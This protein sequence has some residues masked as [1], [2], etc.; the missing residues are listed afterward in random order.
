M[1]LTCCFFVGG[2]AMVNNKLCKYYM[3]ILIICFV[4]CVIGTD[5]MYVLADESYKVY[6]DDEDI[7]EFIDGTGTYFDKA[8][9][10]Y[11]DNEGNVVYCVQAGIAGADKN[12]ISGYN[13]GGAQII[14][15]PELLEKLNHITSLGYPN[16]YSQYA[17]GGT[18]DSPIYSSGLLISGEILK[19]TED[20]A[21]AATAFAIHKLMVDNKSIYPEAAYGNDIT[22]NSYVNKSTA[23]CDMVKIIDKLYSLE[24]KGEASI[25]IEWVIL[26]GEE[27]ITSENP[28][29]TGQGMD[30]YMTL[31]AR[32]TSNNCVV[33]NISLINQEGYV[34]GASIKEIQ[35]LSAFERLV[36]IEIQDNAENYLRNVG[37]NCEAV[38][39]TLSNIKIMG[40]TSYQDIAVVT[41]PGKL[42]QSI[43][44]RFSD[45]KMGIQKLDY[46]TKM[47]IK[48]VTFGLYSDE[49]CNNEIARVITDENGFASLEDIEPGKYY[50]KELDCPLGYVLDDSIYDLDILPDLDTCVV[51]YNQRVPITI[52]INKTDRETGRSEPQGDAKL[53]GAK[54]GVYAAEDI[55]RID[56]CSGIVTKKDELVGQITI[57]FKNMG[58]IDG[59]YPG[60]Y[61]IR[62]I[63]APVGYKLDDTKYFVD[64]TISSHSITDIRQNIV[65]S[66]DV[67]KQ[68][69]QLIK[70]YEGRNDEEIYLEGAGFSAWL[71]SDL[72]TDENGEYIVEGCEPYPIGKDGGIE[73]FTD[74]NGYAC[75]KEIPY[76][77]YLVRETTVPEGF[78]PIED[79]IITISEDSD[80]P[81]ELGMLKDEH[82]VSKI[83]VLKKDFESGVNIVGAELAL[84]D[85]A[86]TEIDR[87][88]S[89]NEEHIIEGLTI[90]EKYIL[91]EI[92]A[93]YG[94]LLANDIEFYP[95][96]LDELLLVMYDKSPKGKITIYKTGEIVETIE[97]KNTAVGVAMGVEVGVKDSWLSGVE[98][99]LYALK[100]VVSPDGS[101][102][103]VYQAGSEIKTVVTNDKGIAEFDDL[104]IG[105][106]YLEETKTKD[107]YIIY[108]DKIYVTLQY[109][110]QYTDTVNVVKNIYNERIKTTVKVIKKDGDTGKYLEGA[111]FG[112]YAKNDIYDSNDNIVHPK[113]YI[114][115]RGVS[116][117]D[118]EI[119]FDTIFFPGTY[120]VKEIEA[121]EGYNLTDEKFEVVILPG[122]NTEVEI[123]VLNYEKSKMTTETTTKIKPETKVLGEKETS[124]QVE[125][126]DASK[127]VLAVMLIIIVM[128][129]FFVMKR[130]C[131]CLKD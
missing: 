15:S 99:K 60:K 104:P 14:K 112:L 123:E 76:G 36:K 8:H 128:C 31:Y 50:I 80:I 44:G 59:L 86:G 39:G 22:I 13:E 24:G 40:N 129:V 85:S 91:K 108:P 117:K 87:W 83:R 114:V 116:D 74:K 124:Q 58:F 77:T 119:I 33:D 121:P 46:S 35:Y 103:I 118:G 73:I 12:G 71:I 88:I 82:D 126:G 2:N 106:Y 131:S 6:A 107:E 81:L 30:E 51:I 102:K 26:E 41:K 111:T 122:K 32:I 42:K 65:V 54:Y 43:T 94:Y 66:D 100:D 127:P 53:N 69:F 19:C 21:H 52:I 29:P 61:Y 47:P 3:V 57:G 37:I 78:L 49:A 89:D 45:G 63:E 67:K 68:A 16:N 20:E 7:R 93:P 110:D 92:K 25:N 84:Y 75:S 56:G 109:V 105:E 28:F 115:A 5:A 70:Y 101:G 34:T 38:S 96:D 98:F 55:M 125:T 97:T 4:L 11:K 17:V 64:C 90:G 120:Y 72:S 27:Y 62:E 23:S 18:N 48:D 1:C 130:F 10:F 9:P 113:D 95:E 79:I